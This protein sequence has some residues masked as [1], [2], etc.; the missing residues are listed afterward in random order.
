MRC[1]EAVLVAEASF[2]ASPPTHPL[3]DLLRRL[4]RV[5]RDVVRPERLV[6]KLTRTAHPP[7]S[8]RP[9]PVIHSSSF[10]NDDL[11]CQRYSSLAQTLLPSLSPICDWLAEDDIQISGARP[12]SAGGFAD[13]WRGTLDTRPVAIKSYRRYLSFDLSH[14]F[15]VGLHR[16]ASCSSRN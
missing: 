10:P 1:S 6:L 4:G 9:L 13:I 8:Q 5:V 7:P 14:V 2:Q 11:L 15:L 3:V 12:V 16:F